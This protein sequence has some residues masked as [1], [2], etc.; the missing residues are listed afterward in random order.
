MKSTNSS[1]YAADISDESSLYVTFDDEEKSPIAF[2][3]EEDEVA[4]VVHPEEIVKSELESAATDSRSESLIS[5]LVERPC[6]GSSFHA[7]ASHLTTLSSCTSEIWYDALDYSCDDLTTPAFSLG[8][9]QS[10]WNG[11]LPGYAQSSLSA[12]GTWI[13]FNSCPS[14]PGTMPGAFNVSEPFDLPFEAPYDWPS[15][16]Q[17]SVSFSDGSPELTSFF[18]G[19]LGDLALAGLPAASSELFVPCLDDP[20]EALRRDML[21]LLCDDS[22]PLSDTA[23]SFQL[24]EDDL[25]LWVLNNAPSGDVSD[26]DVS[27]TVPTSVPSPARAFP[28]A[29]GESFESVD[30]L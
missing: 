28:G 5:H 14:L 10:A 7:S 18:W 22:S 30:D 17:A 11:I 8:D 27:S 9:I 29:W 15:M 21:S 13:G 23:C 12:A 6:E 20:L 4:L 19:S 26:L 3:L 2:K 25:P 16:A 24:P 1:A